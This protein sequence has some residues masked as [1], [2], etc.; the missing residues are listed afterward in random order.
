MKAE[1][2]T[3]I[4][5]AREPGGIEVIEV[6]DR[7]L[8]EPEADEV[9]IRVEAAGVNR[10]DLMERQ[11]LYPPPPGAPE[12]FG[13]EVSGRIAYLGSNVQ[14]LEL[15]D[16]VVAL[17]TGGGYADLARAHKF[18]VLPAPKGISLRDAAGLPET[19][20][21]VW[22]NVFM[23]GA[24]K[25]GETFLIHG[26][27]SGI[28]TT[29]IQMAKAWGAKVYATAG[30]DIKVARC[31]DLGADEAF[32]YRNQPWDQLIRELGG[33][34]VILDMVGG[35]YVERNLSILRDEGRLV[36]IAFQKGSR[37]ELDLMRL[38]MKRLTI[39]GSTLRARSPIEKGGIAQGV[40]DNVWPWVESGQLRPLISETFDLEDAELAHGEMERDSHYGKVLL[41]P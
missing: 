38:M 7:I 41:I 23:R 21:T 8:H 13:L 18:C 6:E 26:G 5:T 36:H 10:P 15:G 27:A 2:Y 35:D 1:R 9:L 11:G 29:A 37:V 3:R 40:Y 30:D 20:F 28:G 32:N 22:A 14:G 19:T 12:G 24:L 4:V 17:V 33:V 16:E 34:D 25:P 31:K 39:T